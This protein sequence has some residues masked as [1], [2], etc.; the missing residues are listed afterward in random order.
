MDIQLGRSRTVR[1]AYG[2]DEIALVPGGRTV[3]PAVTDSSWSLGGITREIPIIADAYVD[4]EFGTGCV[5]ITPAHDF[6]D[7]EIGRRHGLPLINL[8]TADAA[9]NDSAPVAYRGLDRFEARKRIVAASYGVVMFRQQRQALG[10]GRAAGFVLH[11]EF[12][13]EARFVRIQLDSFLQTGDG[14]GDVCLL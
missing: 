9:L 10:H 11:V 13:E 14:F 7:Y 8:F 4:R 12:V 6:N 2:I 3:D 5:K 1:R